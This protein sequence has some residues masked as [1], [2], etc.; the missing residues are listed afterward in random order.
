MLPVFLA[1][2]L[3]FFLSFVNGGND[4]S[5]AIAT[6]AGAGLASVRGAI[7]W[8]TLWTVAGAFAGLLWGGLLIKNINGSIY[9]ESHDFYMPL[10]LAVSVAPILW[11]ALATWRGWPVSTT[12]AIIGGFVGAGL[13][14]YGAGGIEWPHAF[15]KIALPLLVSP[16]LAISLAWFLAPALEK[17][18]RLTNRVRLCLTPAPRLT[19]VASRGTINSRAE[20]SI[21]DC[22]ICDCDSPQAGLTHGVTLSVDNMHWLTSGLLSFSRGLNDAPKLVAVV[23]PFLM[24]DGL[25]APAWLY[26]L[27]ALAMGA[28]SWFAGKNITEVL[29]FNVTKMNHEEGFS[30]NLVA[31]FLVVGAS[32]FGLPV[33]TTHVSASSIMGVGLS[34]QKGLNMSTVKTMLFAWLV[35]VPAAGLFAAIIYMA[36]IALF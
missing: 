8:G 26:F 6:L 9:V 28:G 35:T 32:R 11:V 29:G 21:D 2:V 3:L 18:A 15:S 1:A 34:R 30:A 13:I 19:L 16:F 12:H 33:S 4:V 23:L 10:A 31:A 24:L 27:G 20:A 22:L 14:A 17:S 36:G 5:K 25:A 7:A